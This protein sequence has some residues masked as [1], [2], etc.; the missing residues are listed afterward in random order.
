MVG[1]EEG[2]KERERKGKTRIG[3]N[4]KIPWNKKS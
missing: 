4:G 2:T 1:G 3:D